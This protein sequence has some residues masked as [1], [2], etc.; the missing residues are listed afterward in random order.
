MAA[1]GGRRLQFKSKLGH[2][3]NQTR[4][5]GVKQAIIPELWERITLARFENEARYGSFASVWPRTDDFRSTPDSVAKDPRM[6]GYFSAKE[7]NKRT[8]AGQC[9]F[10]P[11]VGIACEFGVRQRGPPRYYSIVAPMAPRI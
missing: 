5:L 10:S 7:R 4:P 1:Q 6:R 2:Y 8:I 9:S 11:V 3:E